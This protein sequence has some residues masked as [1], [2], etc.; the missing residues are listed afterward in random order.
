MS[1]D[2]LIRDQGEI[3]LR[4]EFDSL[5]DTLELISYAP[6]P[7]NYTNDVNRSS[8]NLI[9]AELF[10]SAS[11]ILDETYKSYENHDNFDNDFS[12]VPYASKIAPYG[13]PFDSK[14]STS[15]YPLDLA[16]NDPSIP[17]SSNVNEIITPKGVVQKKKYKPVAKRIKP[18]VTELPSKYR[19]VQ[20]ILGDPLA[21]MP[22]LDPNPKS[23]EPTGRYT[24]ERRDKLEKV[25]SDFLSRQEL[26]LM[27]DF[28][29]KHNEGFAWIDSERGSF[30][31]DF[32]PP[33]DIPTIPHTPWIE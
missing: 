11:G 26:D 7:F 33:I 21:N 13:L 29:C 3:A 14:S 18:V 12:F 24:Q 20:N 2:D 27:H 5:S 1:F 22:T 4:L 16:S 23:F 10:A 9:L 25:H 19:I 31:K 30:R 15:V 28:M 17:S 32:F 6:I 8:E